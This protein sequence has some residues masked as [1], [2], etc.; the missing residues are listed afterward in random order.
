MS[1]SGLIYAAV[2]GAWA[3]YFVSRS[4][5][6]GPREVLVPPQG[7]V[8]RRRGSTQVP[9][10]S[11]AMIRPPAEEPAEPVVKPRRSDV[12]VP[13]SPVPVS[14]ST[15]RRRRLMLT[16]LTLST[17]VPGVLAGVG[18]LAGWTVGIPGLLLLTYL[19]EL[20]ASVRRVRR[21][22]SAAALESVE[23]GARRTLRWARHRQT[24]DVW[25]DPWPCFDPPDASGGG[26]QSDL[27]G[28]WEPRPVPLPTYLSSTSKS[29]PGAAAAA[30]S[31]R[32][33]TSGSVWTAAA[34]PR[35]GQT[36]LDG[37]VSVRTVVNLT[38]A[39]PAP[40][41]AAAVADPAIAAELEVEFEQKRAVND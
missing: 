2:L 33:D 25:E 27:V 4:I 18:L 12:A 6:F 20:R 21:A 36:D 22:C 15:A 10:G 3:V 41:D 1:G 34:E 32:I 5:R 30:G 31:R 35:S 9:A 39:T 23:G 7:A 24:E 11:Y 8:L 26:R 37:E 14:A 29:S 40:D 38:K 28:G 13:P 16:L 19:V 17:V